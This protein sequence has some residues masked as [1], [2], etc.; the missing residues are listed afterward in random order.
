MHAG[1]AIAVRVRG[2]RLDG[3]AHDGGAVAAFFAPGKDP[4]HV[5]GDREPDRQAALGFD[6]VTRVYGAQ[7]RTAGW[8]PG[9]WTCRG[10]VLGADG[11]PEGWAWFAFPLDP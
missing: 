1:E 3:T 2:N 7:V 5:P 11:V 8:A 4:E 9:T 6:P 10:T